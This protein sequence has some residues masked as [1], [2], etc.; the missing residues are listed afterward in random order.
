MSYTWK[1]ACVN[2][3]V[4]FR[5]K[6]GDIDGALRLSKFAGGANNSIEEAACE[7]LRRTPET[8]SAWIPKELQ[9]IECKPGQYT[10]SDGSTCV[11]CE[12]GLFQAV[13]RPFVP[14]LS[15]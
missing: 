5:L 7:W 9:T 6:N 14:F 8:W 10:G 1:K 3:F 15:P 11:E 12:A 4:R 13:C 2:G